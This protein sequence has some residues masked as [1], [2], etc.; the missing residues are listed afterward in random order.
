MSWIDPVI[1][2]ILALYAY[3]GWKRGFISVAAGLAVLGLSVGIAAILY[4]PLSVAVRAV[5]ASEAGAKAFAFL[6]VWVVSVAAG[7]ILSMKWLKGLPESTV[8]SSLNKTAGTLPG[9]TEGLVLISFVALLIVVVPGR[10]G[11]KQAVGE[12]ALCR[13][14]I[15]GAAV[16]QKMASNVFGEAIQG[17]MSFVTVRPEID[18]TERLDLKFKTTDVQADPAAEARMLDLVNQERKAVGVKPLVLD[19][20]LTAVG[21]AHARDMFAHGYFSHVNLRGE[22][23]F[24]RMRKHDIQYQVAGEN[25]ALAPTVDI[26]HNG[27]MNSPGHRANILSP[28]FHRIGIGAIS[29]SIRG[30]M[31]AQEFTD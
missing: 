31:F 20:K 22:S 6:L 17:A 3:R 12:S 23:P 19:L 13:P 14:L 21:R 11:M 7:S 18:S 16:V 5:G 8:E 28:E 4:G 10:G 26:A 24:A 15:S 9:M 2:I 29:N 30:I 27:L 25:L 1:I